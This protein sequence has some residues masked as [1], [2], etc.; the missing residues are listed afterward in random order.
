MTDADRDYALADQKARLSSLERA[1]EEIKKEQITAREREQSMQLGAATMNGEVVNLL[2]ALANHELWH[3]EHD[4]KGY[5][6]AALVT[7]MC[8]V[9][10]A[11]MVFIWGKP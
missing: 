1:V 5:N 8:S 10:V 9:A 11:I 7:S 3:K 2:K 4:A 6:I